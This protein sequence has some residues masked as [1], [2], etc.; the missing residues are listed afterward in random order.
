[1]AIQ[2]LSGIYSNHQP[3]SSDLFSLTKISDVLV[4]CETRVSNNTDI[5]T[6]F[7]DRY[8]AITYSQTS[9][10]PVRS[11]APR[12]LNSLT[13]YSVKP[14]HSCSLRHNFSVCKKC[15]IS[16]AVFNLIPRTLPTHGNRKLLGVHVRDVHQ[17]KR[18][19]TRQT[20]VIFVAR[21]KYR[22]GGNR[23]SL[24]TNPKMVSVCIFV[25]EITR[26]LCT[27]RFIYFSQ[28]CK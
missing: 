25:T 11:A 13:P 6:D 5:N 24:M 1:M 7:M 22:Y 26:T 18:G 27:L 3:L 17:S 21:W 28:F 9:R 4:D 23:G 12:N 8:T 14:N 19:H 16:R 10:I 20:L 15:Y 2:P